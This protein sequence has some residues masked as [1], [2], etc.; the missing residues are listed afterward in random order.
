LN[1]KSSPSIRLYFL[2]QHPPVGD[3]PRPQE[4]A[5]LH[6]PPLFY[7][8]KISS[9]GGGRVWA[10]SYDAAQN[11]LEGGTA[12]PLGDGGGGGG[13]QPQHPR[14]LSLPPASKPSCCIIRFRR[15]NL[16][17][18]QEG[19]DAGGEDAGPLFFSA[20]R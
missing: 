17:M 4:G 2:P 14:N 15:R 1:V 18:Q 13:K 3:K 9:I 6:P 5:P 10:E 11:P 20:M 7:P 8:I 12:S 16:M 19:L